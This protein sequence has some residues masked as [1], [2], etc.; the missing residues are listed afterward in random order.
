MVDES[1]SSGWRPSRSGKQQASDFPI[2]SSLQDPD[3]QRHTV[4]LRDPHAAMAGT[5]AGL[6]RRQVVEAGRW[7]HSSRPRR[8]AASQREDE[9]DVLYRSFG[10]RRSHGGG[11]VELQ[12]PRASGLG[13]EEHLPRGRTGASGAGDTADGA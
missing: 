2:S 5:E 9:D 12:L 4:T 11:V 1:W 7:E 3:R 10:E 8:C 13:A 6:E